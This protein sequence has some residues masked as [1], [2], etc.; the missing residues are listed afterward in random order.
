MVIHVKVIPCGGKII[1]AAMQKYSFAS[2]LTIITNEYV[3]CRHLKFSMEI[4]REDTYLLHIKYKSK[5]R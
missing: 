2:G 1:M 5:K 3:G 4:N